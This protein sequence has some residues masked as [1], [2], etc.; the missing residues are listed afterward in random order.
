MLTGDNK[1]NERVSLTVS[2][3]GDQSMT[4][5]AAL[6]ELGR[7]DMDLVGIVAIHLDQTVL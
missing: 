3:N 5:K 7:C 1:S 2:A 4:L 6:L